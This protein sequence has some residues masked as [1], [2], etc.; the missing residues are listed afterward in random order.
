[1]RQ[2]LDS[3]PVRVFWKDRAGRY[4]GAN[5]LCATDLGF[6]SPEEMV[7][8]LDESFSLREEADRYHA[9]DLAVMSSGRPRLNFEEPQTR[10]GGE[11][12]WLLTSKIPMR[13]VGGEVVGV[14][15]IYEDVTERKQML[16]ELNEQEAK[17]TLALESAAM[18][19]W[20]WHID[21]NRVIWSDQ[22]AVIF[23]INLADFQG[24]LE[25]Y[26]QRIHP[27]D[28]AEMELKIREILEHP[29]IQYHVEHRVV[30]PDGS[31]RWIEAR[32]NLFRDEAGEPR[33]MTGMLWDVTRR[34][35]T[36]GNLLRIAQ[37]VGGL[38]GET[39]IQSVLATLGEVTQADFALLGRLQPDRS[40][41]IVA[42]HADGRPTESHRHQISE[43]LRA[44]VLEN[45]ICVIPSGVQQRFPEDPLLN[46]LQAEACAAASLP[47]S[48]GRPVGL[49]VAVFRRPLAHADEVQSVVGILAAA[50][51]ADMERSAASDA[52]KRA[53]LELEERVRERTDEL[54]R[55]VNLMAG[56]EIRMAELKAEIRKLRMPNESEGEPV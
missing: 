19:I 43:A 2:V 37:G 41:E 29:G 34:K 1:L 38:S 28:V 45:E 53:N 56:R 17:L 15:G 42:A 5:R 31:L 50:A 55:L 32:G 7:G 20:E 25:D 46:E 33:R 13:E 35:A 24:T 11:K 14:L 22:V 21:T 40:I 54:Q 10:P 39:L 52:L 30:R 8:Q 51:A 6:E 9:D 3:I 23:G 48:N 18:G 36:E 4:L 49:L 47:D 12:R 44:H 27:D 16:L 26:Q